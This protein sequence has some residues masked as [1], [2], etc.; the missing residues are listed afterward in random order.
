MTILRKFSKVKRY[1]QK[2]PGVVVAFSGGVDSSLLLR[3]AQEELDNRVIAV[4]A[5]SP[6]HPRAELVR[7]K[8]IA[9][10]LRCRHVII[11]TRDLHNEALVRNARN[12]C[13]ICKKSFFAQAK[14]Y[15][16]EHGYVIVEAS[17]VSDLGDF[18][19]GL[20]ALKELGI[21]SPFIDAGVTKREIRAM[22]RRYHLPN[23]NEPAAAC[24]AS[25]IPYGVRIT[26]KVLTRIEKAECY[27]RRF[28]I[29]QVRARDHYPLV[30]IEVLPKDI[31]IILKA[32]PSI[33]RYFRR[34]G[35]T[36]IVLDLEGYSIG[37]L[38]KLR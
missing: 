26:T 27:L 33:V 23:W 22:A 29:L 11:R 7:A 6:I 12:R 19:P 37:S 38:N 18:R 16:R 1:L 5:S 9:R 14:T 20:R 28:E 34:L 21:N 25:R 4:T 31:E 17:N 10:Q 2:Q 36:Y 32:R 30:R 13:Y 35:Y 8:R 3:I 24:L 15:A